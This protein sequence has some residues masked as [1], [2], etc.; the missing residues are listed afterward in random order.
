MQ[1]LRSVPRLAQRAVWQRNL[2]SRVR[3][4]STAASKTLKIGG[5]DVS[6]PTGLFINNE[7]RKSIGG[8]TFGVE[9]P[10]TGR[11]IL[12][13]EE[14][15]EEDVNEAVR[16]ARRT[17]ESPEWSGINP[18]HRGDLLNKL[19]VLM[20]RDKEEIIALEMIDTGK[21]Y[22]QAS[23]LDFPG[24]V[25][26]LKYYAG[27]A[28]KLNG[29]TSFNIPGAFAYTRREAVGVCGQI[30][31][32]NFP[33]LMFTWKIAP[34]VVTGNTVVIKSAEATPLS[35]LKVCELIKEAGFPEGVVNLVSGYGKTVGNAIANHMDIDKVAFTGSTGTGRHVLK[36]SANS[37]LKKVTLELGGKSPNIV[38]PDADFEKTIDWSAWGINMNFGQT[39]HAGTRIYV[40][41]DIY[42][43]FVDAYSKTMA[44]LKVGDNFDPTVDQGPQ[45]SRMQHEKILGY[46]ESGK[47]E[48]AT[49][50]LGGKVAQ[51]G[52]D[53]GY[54]IEPTIFTNATPD[55]KIM[56]EEIF[57]PVVVI[58]R[59]SDEADVIKHANDTTYGLAA[60][61]HTQ[62]Y[63][64]AIRV[65]NALKAG[66]NWVNMYNFVHWSIPFGGYKQS[67]IGRECGEAVLENYTETKAVYMNMGIAAPK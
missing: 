43:K 27:F 38:F 21:T 25:G 9:N 67:G 26:T 49:V 18:S 58:S 33:L 5:R 32:W 29:L 41:E 36:S 23:N 53:G 17:F 59:F 19:A 37:N 40:H 3:L 57:G 8:N 11:E 47:Q 51:V 46:I 30:I 66:T 56:K 39:C 7:F 60:A 2:I 63:E 61:V 16:V 54:Y 15:R 4:A 6:V 34:A 52:S 22:K 62:D 55:M 42:D 12:Q 10:A 31:P 13:I 50:H 35:A 45:N 65:T 44:K 28:D 24:S 64:R 48:G 20:E 1:S 14:G